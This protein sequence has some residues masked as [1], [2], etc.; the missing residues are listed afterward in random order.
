MDSL[1]YGLERLIEPEAHVFSCKADPVKGR[2]LVIGVDL[3]DFEDWELI[4]ERG[5]THELEFGGRH[6]GLEHDD[7]CSL[8]LRLVLLELCIDCL[9]S[10]G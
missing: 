8:E 1:F 10:R 6:V 7:S 9:K 4:N 2:K 5:K 3:L